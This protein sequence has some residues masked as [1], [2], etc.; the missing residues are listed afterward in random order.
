M[1]IMQG[2]F[3]PISEL[4]TYHSKWTIR[5]RVTSKAQ[6]RTFRKGNGEGKV[7]HVELLDAEGGEI[8]A[9][10]FNDAV[11]QFHNKLDKGK[12][13][14]FSGGSLRVANKQFNTCNHRYEITFDRGARIE[15]VED[16]AQIGKHVFK[17]TDLRA[18]QSRATP[19]TA[20]LCGVVSGFQP[21]LAF[22]SKDGKELVKREVT[23]T[24]DTATS[25]AVT[26]WGER[27]KQADTT[28]AGHPAVV[29]KGVA[30]KEWNGGRSGSLLEGGD[31]IFDAHLPEVQK[32][33]Q[34]WSEGGS[35]KEIKALSVSGPG[36]R[37]P[38]GTAVE[39]L[40]DLRRH[41]EQVVGDQGKVFTVVARLAQVQMRKQGE[42]QPKFYMGCQEPKEGNGHPCNRR[43]DET[44]F[45]A[46]CNRTGKSAPRL[47]L[48][49][50]FADF[51]DSPWLTTF[52]E[53]AQKVVGLSAERMKA[54]EESEG[55][56]ALESAIKAAYMLEPVQLTVR[57]RYESYNGEPR[58]NV[59]CIDAR[60]VS[61]G[62]RGRALLQEIGQMVSA[63]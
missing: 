56:E 15:E 19:F 22:T 30:V 14:T 24:D 33:K 10:F 38:S 16:V 52:H 60:P 4:S 7:F 25:I 45:C 62:E 46:A 27:A 54:L 47:N 63:K 58:T 5:A 48:R 50:K 1:A 35:S 36:S 26:I 12:C 53:A 20:D 41:A 31:L 34:W 21:V 3:F 2:A 49:C 23:L 11:D 29:M 18:I 61:W 17:V 59:T 43:V 32:M 6:I 28:F 37:G 13:F 9:S 42:A 57:A 8:R 44:G 51:T 40:G 55:R 39:D